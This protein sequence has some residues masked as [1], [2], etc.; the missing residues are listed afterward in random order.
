MLGYSDTD[1]SDE[2]GDI[3]TITIENVCPRGS[4]TYLLTDSTDVAHL[5][6]AHS[7]LQ[8]DQDKEVTVPPVAYTLDVGHAADPFEMLESMG[9]SAHVHLHGSTTN[10]DVARR[11]LRNTYNLDADDTVV[12]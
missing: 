12:L 9:A 2:I 4:F 8:A 7:Q 11:Q 5:E 1:P 3:P 10:T 6:T